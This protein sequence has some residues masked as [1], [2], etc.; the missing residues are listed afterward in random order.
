MH[1][2]N[3][4]NSITIGNDVVVYD[5]IFGIMSGTVVGFTPKKVR[6]KL[7]STNSINTYL[8]NPKKVFVLNGIYIK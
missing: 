2:D 1:I 5:Y 8:Y 3:A 4:F 7:K 6:V